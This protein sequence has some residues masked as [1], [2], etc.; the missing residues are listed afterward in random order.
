MVTIQSESPT[1][2]PWPPVLQVCSSRQSRLP[3]DSPDRP[4]ALAVDRIACVYR[5]LPDLGDAFRPPPPELTKAAIARSIS[6]S[7]HRQGLSF[8]PIPRLAQDEEPECARG[9][10]GG[11]GGLGQRAMAVTTAGKNRIM[12]YGP[13][14]EG[15]YLVEFRTAAAPTLK[16]DGPSTRPA[17]CCP[18]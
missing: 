17:E 8:G 9:D 2:L 3:D 13:K 7:A 16:T 18:A 11:R 12:M 1:S 4:P 6:R 10:T 15:T 5:K 14:A